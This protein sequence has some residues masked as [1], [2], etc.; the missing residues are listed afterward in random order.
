MGGGARL[1]ISHSIHLCF[2]K[3]ERERTREKHLQA[4]H[5]ST[6]LSLHVALLYLCPCQLH[7]NLCTQKKEK[8]T[9]DRGEEGVCV[10]A[11]ACFRCTN[12]HDEW[13]R[14]GRLDFVFDVA[15]QA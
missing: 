13:D 10:C 2:S 3:K 11:R 1:Y 6:N 8:K 15:H 4:I 12:V 14:G 5:V 7:S 9:D